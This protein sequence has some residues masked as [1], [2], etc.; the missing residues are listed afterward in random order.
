MGNAGACGCDRE[1]DLTEKGELVSRWADPIAEPRYR[2][3]DMLQNKL[4][5]E[6]SIQVN[7]E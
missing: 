7:T 3:R 6:D 1:C 5:L 2:N 4:H